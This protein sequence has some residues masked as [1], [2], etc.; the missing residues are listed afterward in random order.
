MIKQ[1]GKLVT[2]SISCALLGIVSGAMLGALFGG[3]VLYTTFL[4][5][6]RV[7]FA[8]TMPLV[9][10]VLGGIGGIMAGLIGGSFSGLRGFCVGGLIGGVFSVALLVPHHTPPTA[11]VCTAAT[12]G[13]IFGLWVDWQMT[14]PASPFPIIRRCQA[15]FKHCSIADVPL[16]LRYSF[17][18]LVSLGCILLVLNTLS[19]STPAQRLPDPPAH[20]RLLR[21]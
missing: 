8:A 18:A 15:V 6:S 4:T 5:H 16:W 3:C 21:S 11:L 7:Q 13:A 12:I 19:V 14:K 1:L 2:V 9:A 17:G 20:H 10:M